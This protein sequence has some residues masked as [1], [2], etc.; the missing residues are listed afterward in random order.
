MKCHRPTVHSTEIWSLSVT[1]PP[2]TYY[3]NVITSLSLLYKLNI[4]LQNQVYGCWQVLCYNH[5]TKKF[6]KRL[7]LRSMIQGITPEMG[8]PT[9][10]VHTVKL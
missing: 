8:Q 10:L 9:N 7:L 5:D 1:P 2:V 6:S 3:H 4:K